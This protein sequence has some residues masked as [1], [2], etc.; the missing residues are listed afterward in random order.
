M[1]T[2]SDTALDLHDEYPLHYRVALAELGIHEVHGAAANPRITTYMKCCKDLSRADQANDEVPWCS[3][4]CCWVVESAGMIS[5]RSASAISWA[6]W[7]V[8]VDSPTLGDLMV[9]KRVG[10]HHV[11]LFSGWVGSQLFRGLGG[12]QNNAVCI[13]TYPKTD[14]IAIRRP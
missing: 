3:A 1:T 6:T 7:G 4:Y 9:L 11:T 12:N 13:A 10:G 2:E 14:V 5:T 8:R